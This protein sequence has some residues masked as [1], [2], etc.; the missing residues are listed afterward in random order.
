MSNNKNNDENSLREKVNN[1]QLDIIEL[2]NISFLILKYKFSAFFIVI[3]LFSIPLNI[4]MF[5]YPLPMLNLDVSSVTEAISIFNEYFIKSFS[6]NIV[7]NLILSSLQIAAV[8]FI[9]QKVIAG[10][11]VD[12]GTSVLYSV[13]VF[14]KV[15]IT[16]VLFILII[17]IGTLLFILP[18]IV[19]GLFFG[20]AVYIASS[21]KCYGIEAFK[22][23]AKLVRTNIIKVL[24]VFSFMMLFQFSYSMI[25]G[26]YSPADVSQIYTIIYDVVSY[27]I[28][29]LLIGYLNIMVSLLFINMYN[30][31]NGKVLDKIIK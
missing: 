12:A 1:T 28:F 16:Y 14:P 20:F 19:A 25:L 4:L 3:L 24:L 7:A 27:V 2:F 9:V 10:K 17:S 6:I 31:G 29:Y 23:S 22:Y 15:L 5:I 18:G 21:K 26:I 30:N 8:M 11:Y 13:R